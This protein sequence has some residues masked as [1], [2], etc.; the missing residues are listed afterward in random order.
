MLRI[1]VT[2]QLFLLVIYSFI[3]IIV[4]LTPDFA[5]LKPAL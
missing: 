3:V 5:I 4:Q 2:G 1:D